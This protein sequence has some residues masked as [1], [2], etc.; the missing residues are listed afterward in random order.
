MYKRG[1]KDI[2]NPTN[3]NIHPNLIMLLM[4]R[5]VGNCYSEII[6][7]TAQFASTNT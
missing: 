2:Y 6:Y 4:G 1:K 7:S 3:L 5:F